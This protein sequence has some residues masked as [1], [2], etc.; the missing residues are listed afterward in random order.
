MVRDRDRDRVRDRDYRSEPN[1]LKT[2]CHKNVPGITLAMAAPSDGRPQPKAGL[3]T[4]EFYRDPLFTGDPTFNRTQVS[5]FWH[6][7][8][9]RHLL[10]HWLRVF[11]L[12]LHYP[13]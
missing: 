6:L 4:M 13:C 10:E 11:I 3:E 1:L 9:T 2:T 12:I 8:E 5:K 7:I